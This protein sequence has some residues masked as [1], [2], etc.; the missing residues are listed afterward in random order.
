MIEKN[1]NVK[2]PSID[3]S[4]QAVIPDG[5]IVD[6]ITGQWVKE[7]EQE[8]VRQN[9]ERTLVEE[10]N[11]STK[12][13]RVDFKIKVWDGSRQLTKKVPLAVMK[14]ESENPCILI[15]VNKPKSDPTDKKNGFDELEQW[16]VDV[17]TAEFGCWTNGIENLFIQKRKS[18]FETDVFPV[19]DFPQMLFA[20]SSLLW[21]ISAK[22]M[23]DAPF[24]EAN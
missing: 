12:D 20:I 24:I 15:L 9:F 16:M 1:N 2:E 5:K 11:Y 8:K 18:K 19:N 10:Y 7:S 14:E 22:K 3:Y 4:S 13:I 23:V 17:K 6:Y 21:S